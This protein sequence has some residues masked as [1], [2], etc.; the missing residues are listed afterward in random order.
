M[1]G[2]GKG[3]G[4]VLVVGGGIAGIQGS[5]DLAEAGFHVYLVESAPTIGRI[6][7]QLDKT[8]PTNDCSMCIMSPKLV[9]CARH[10]NIDL[11]TLSEVQDL[12]GGPG[13]FTVT[14]RR[15]ARHVL[16]D[17]CTGCGECEK[18]CP[19]RL[20]NEF[21]ERLSQRRA[22]Y[23]PFPQA[24]PNVFAIQKEGQSPCAAACPAGCNAH[25][26]VA[27]IRE[28]KW[29]EALDLIRERIPL[30]AV[31]GRVCGLCEE[32][33][34]RAN[35]DEAVQIRALKRFAA[36]YEMR[37]A[38]LSEGPE[39]ASPPRN[40]GPRIAILGSGP[41]GLTA[42][43]DLAKMGYR[44][45]VFEARL[46]SGGMLR[47]GIPQYRLPDHVLDYEIDVIR[48]QGVEI[49]LGSAASADVE[50]LRQQGYAAVFSAV[51]AQRSRCLS[52]PGE[53]LGGVLQALDFLRGAAE[54]SAKI[55]VG[56]GVAVIGG[57][58]TA[59][60][61]ARTACRLG[62]ARTLLIYRRT[63]EEMPALPDEVTA[64]QE[65][66]VELHFLLAPRRIVG[67]D[68]TDGTVSRIEC[69]KMRLG[70]PDESGRRS[71]V[72][73]EGEVESFSTDVVIAAL[74]QEV[75][76]A[77]AEAGEENLSLRG[78]LLLVDPVTLETNVPGVFAGGDAAGAGGYVV[79][80]IAHGHAAAVSIDRLLKG[81]DLRAGREKV[82]L[83]KALISEEYRVRRS[84]V[85]M[86][87]AAMKTRVSGFEEVELG[88]TE[89]QAVQEAA[90][91]L[92]CGVCSECMQCVAH[93]EAKAIDHT[94]QD[95]ILSLRVGAVL[96]AAGCEKYDPKGSYVLGYGSYEDV[97]TSVQFERILSASGPYGGHVRRPSD[98]RIPRRIAFVQCV[99]SR[100]PVE[101]REHC[102]SVC[103]M[104]AIKEAVIAKEH[105]R[106]IEPTIFYM[107]IRAHGKDFDRYFER[108]RSEYG[109]RFRRA[110][111]SGVSRD[112][113]TGALLVQ[114]EDE[115]GLVSREPFD[116]VVLSIGFSPGS[117]LRGL[118]D[119]LH[120]PLNGFGF[121][122]TNPF[123]PVE[124]TAPGIFV[125]GPAQEP[126]DIPETVTQA[127]AGAAGAAGVLAA[128]RWTEVREKIFPEEKDVQGQP[129]RIGVFVCHCGINIG[130]TVRVPEVVE[131][132]RTLGD[133]VHAEANLYTC[134]QDTQG[135]IR[136]IVLEHDL[137]RVV[138]ASCTPRTHEPLFQETIQEAGLNR[139]L[140]EMANIRD[141]CS[142]IHAGLP[143]RATEKARDL[144][145]MA[146]AKARLAEPLPTMPLDVAQRALVIGGGPAGMS[147]ALSL[148][149][150]GFPVDLV[151]RDG[152]LG[153]NLNHVHIAPDGRATRGLL[154]A[155]VA[156][157]TGHPRIVVHTGA[158]VR[159]VEGF[160]GQFKSTVRERGRLPVAPSGLAPTQ[161]LR[162]TSTPEGGDGKAADERVI[163]HGVTILATGARESRPAAYHYG[164]D[165]RVKTGL[166]FES[167]LSQTPAQGLP[168]RVVFIQCVG[169]RD[170]E[171]PYCSRVCCTQTVK[172]AL[173]L[174]RKKPDCEVYVLYR[175]I[176]TYGLSE[177]FYRQAREA[178][179]LFLRYED[180]E[181]PE[182]T[183]GG[184]EMQVA[185]RDSLSGERLVLQPGLVVLASRIDPE[186][187]NEEMSRLYK[188][189][190]NQ[191]RFFL[192]AHVK[193]RPVDFA[194]EGVYVAGMA[195]NP[196]TIEES[197]VQGG[198]AAARAAT[199]ISKDKYL[200]EATIAAVNDDLCDGC[201]I[202]VGV[203]EYKALDVVQQPNGKKLVKLNEAA[204]KGCG[205]CVA[206]CP[207]GAMEQKGYKSAQIMAE[208]DA[209][210]A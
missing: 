105:E 68:G 72:P 123:N 71:P 129:P 182:V 173:A 199:I 198:A 35:V 57:G 102:S 191:D 100:E 61:T 90:R 45:V 84:R 10:R 33:C 53:D 18:Y 75:E 203:C 46:K 154:D 132:A 79:H 5:L 185:V 118:A 106:Q 22:I 158:E 143:D 178:G 97:V 101:G 27:L 69:T 8:F 181:K 94:Q 175:D 81:Q 91:C 3:S 58:N 168:E 64:A 96:V 153:G 98:G 28:R 113:V 20:P 109:I 50:R 140:F 104:Y 196:K 163:A 37:Q 195:H 121:I 187:G 107:D 183:A 13:D 110:R 201:G 26:Y 160:V 19:V 15:A 138:V 44:P 136:D 186:P 86:P 184:G 34:S 197:I 141:Q 161:A 59:I 6:M 29:V 172:N 188:V 49:R 180:T 142:W 115:T 14:V 165:E 48:R 21:D 131:Y 80:A 133:V 124:T 24:A 11:L 74:G 38:A 32:A 137:N 88:F 12:V 55:V 206:S 146:V 93:C 112:E 41:A 171:H 202:C 174:R 9:D 47:Y 51:G 169:S 73:V 144:V 194:M 82:A 16:E 108:A 147:A 39:A 164:E 7:A 117:K 89:E 63:I 62:A 40:D 83:P 54:G 36:D 177:R 204:C 192:E 190:L 67:T 155:M 87:R 17:K 176:R 66:G 193:L 95:E 76:P 119:R 70:P 31:C 159:A 157:V 116:L 200:A 145:R 2:N 56:K 167:Y 25:G 130:G 151:E 156:R 135:H 92:D 208:I 179:V 152:R 149:D 78:G 128:G 120:V 170:T 85:P 125:C 65:E 122:A 126:K 111:V 42:A 148:A 139:H 205:C 189:P 1:N 4:S 207:S 166:E 210:L 162:A 43:Y 60:D 127:S 114:R 103:C 23:R 99:G 52:V 150:Q 209:A 77:A 134:S 30:P